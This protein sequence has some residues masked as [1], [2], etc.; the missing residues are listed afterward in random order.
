MPQL[1]WIAKKP[2]NAIVEDP[3]RKLYNSPRWRAARASFLSA[4]PLC[5]YCPEDGITTV[6]N[7]VDHFVNVRSGQVDFWDE[8]NWRASCERCHNIKRQAERG[9]VKYLPHAGRKE[10]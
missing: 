10:Q 5:S 6:A 7:T 2:K 8:S 1:P 4:N 9:T 3:F